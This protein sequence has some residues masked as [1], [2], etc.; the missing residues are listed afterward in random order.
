M[1]SNWQRVNSGELYQLGTDDMAMEKNSLNVMSNNHRYWK[2]TTQSSI[3]SQWVKGVSMAWR[4]HQLQFL[5]QGKG[6]YNLYFGANDLRK[7]APSHWYQQLNSQLTKDLFSD[8]IQVG[9]LQQLTPKPV[10]VEAKPESSISRYVFWGLLVVVLS[11]LF[12]MASRLMKEV[13]NED[14]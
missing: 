7:A 4:P 8:Q 13:S 9:S 1:Q 14:N 2:L 6:P 11:A 3:S 12:Y 5:A 10:V